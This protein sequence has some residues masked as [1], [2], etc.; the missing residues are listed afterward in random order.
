MVKRSCSAR[1]DSAAIRLETARP[2]IH[3]ETAK[4]NSNER[5]RRSQAAAVTLGPSAL[6]MA[7]LSAEADA[8]TDSLKGAQE[9]AKTSSECPL[10][11]C[12]RAPN[13]RRSHRPTSESAPPVSSRCSENG[14]NETLFTCGDEA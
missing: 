2:A 8:N 6:T 10:N 14:L 12:S 7:R 9:T 11:V 4:P 13:E 3:I 1:N 5:S